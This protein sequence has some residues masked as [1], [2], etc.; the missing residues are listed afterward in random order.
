[1][2]GVILF[3]G[4]L[5]LNS[6]IKLDMS[7]PSCAWAVVSTLNWS[8]S[9]AQRPGAASQEKGA[10]TTSTYRNLLNGT[11]QQLFMAIRL[12]NPFIIGQEITLTVS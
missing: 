3:K 2:V 1:M 10:F 12:P 7:R 5:L 11:F 6:I 9:L 4:N 8:V